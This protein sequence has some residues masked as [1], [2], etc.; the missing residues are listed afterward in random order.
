M[1]SKIVAQAV[2]AA[3]RAFMAACGAIPIRRERVVFSSFS[4]K[5]YSDNPRAISER[6]HE[7]RPQAEIVWLMRDGAAGSLPGYARR[8]RPNSLRAIYLMATARAWVDNMPK[9]LYTVKRARQF[10]V[11]TWHG[12]RGFKKMLYD[13]PDH[14][15]GKPILEER[16]ADVM[17]A[18]SRFCE[19]TFRT[20][21]RF[22]GEVMQVGSPRNDVLTLP[23]GQTRPG[24]CARLGLDENARYMLYAP[25]M[26]RQAARTHGLQPIQDIDLIRALDCLSARD[27][28]EYRCLVR[29]HSTALGLDG[30]PEDARVIDVSGYEDM[31]DILLASDVLIT[32]YSSCAGDFALT[33]RQIALYQSDRESF[34]REERT[35]Y[36]DIDASPYQAAFSQSELEAL[37]LR[38]DAQSAR[39]NDEEILAFYGCT[40]TGHAAG[41]V[42]EKIIEA[43]RRGG[44][45]S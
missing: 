22:R 28:C 36:F 17:V 8:A 9:P 40:E 33:G 18:G 44:A 7:M 24:A 15:P 21:F 30:L 45:R 2:H 43:I 27:G 25:T 3:R 10:Y 5:S 1:P 11:Q 38:A 14:P 42:C 35:F 6:L 4:G 31:A 23:A 13:A 16:I 34:E 39:H 19:E 26:R 32:D 20:G 41:R 29:C 12:D 37:L